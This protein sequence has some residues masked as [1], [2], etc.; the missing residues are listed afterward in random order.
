MRA[1]RSPA[2]QLPSR[3]PDRNSIRVAS[4]GLARTKQDNPL[5]IKHA[6]CS[7]KVSPA[8]V[9]TKPRHI[10]GALQELR[11]PAHGRL[12]RVHTSYHRDPGSSIMSRYSVKFERDLYSKEMGRKTFFRRSVVARSGGMVETRLCARMAWLPAPVAWQQGGHTRCQI[13]PHAPSICWCHCYL[14]FG[15]EAFVII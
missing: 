5:T 3:S 9:Q 14:F 8:G 7:V 15:T 6:D 12:I 1:P 10:L 13:K 2:N 11:K 4:P